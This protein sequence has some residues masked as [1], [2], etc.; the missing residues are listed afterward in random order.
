MRAELA[1][2]RDDKQWLAT[3]PPA[4]RN[5]YVAKWRVDGVL[6]EL[7]PLSDE[8]EAAWARGERK[9]YVTV[10]TREQYL[11]GLYAL[12]VSIVRSGA[13]HP[14]AAML[15]AELIAQEQVRANLT[16]AGFHFVRV[17]EEIFNP[18]ITIGKLSQVHKT[19]I[20]T[21]LRVFELVEFE[22]V[23][24][25]DG[26]T[27]VARNIDALFEYDDNFAIAPEI[28]GIKNCEH[29]GF[30]RF[31]FEEAGRQYCR[32]HSKEPYHGR[33]YQYSNR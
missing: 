20:F 32:S 28:M 24:Y 2:L 4:L 29:D 14:I 16:A 17:I 15:S 6:R 26:D 23:V 7:N 10:A 8:Q 11:V 12:G 27:V 3:L 5:I 1:V 25:L 21:K 22:Q 19:G 33:T 13:K 18:A 9:A 30:E 31:I